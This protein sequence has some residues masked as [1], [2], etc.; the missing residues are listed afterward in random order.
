V[1]PSAAGIIHYG[2]TSCFVTDNAELILM[3]EAM[4][5][6]LKKLA[7]VISNLSAFALKWKGNDP[8]DE[9]PIVAP[10]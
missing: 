10:C 4:D 7:K 3:R 1:A 5:L 9:R 6:L 2:A 8:A